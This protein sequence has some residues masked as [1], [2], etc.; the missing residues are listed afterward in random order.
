MHGQSCCF[1]QQT[2]CFFDVLVAVAVV[3]AEAR[4]Y[5]GSQAA[6]WLCRFGFRVEEV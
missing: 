4:Y 2:Y 5:I 6:S 3:V 1:A